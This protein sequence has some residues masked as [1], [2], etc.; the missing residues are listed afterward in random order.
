LHIAGRRTSWQPAMD[1]DASFG[2]VASA[3]CG[4]T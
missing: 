3:I 4:A 1:R 2:W